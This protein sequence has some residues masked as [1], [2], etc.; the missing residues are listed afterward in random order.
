MV[1]LVASAGVPASRLVVKP[2]FVP[3]GPVGEGPGGYALFAGRLSAGNDRGLRQHHAL[4]NEI[5]ITI[6]IA[7]GLAIA[8]Y[9]TAGR[10]ADQLE[11]TSLVEL[12]QPLSKYAAWNGTP[13]TSRNTAR[14]PARYQVFSGGCGC[15]RIETFWPRKT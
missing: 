7:F 2:N 11:N 15:P 4:I 12:N 8:V 13:W 1:P 10:V 5:P 9:T 14:S 6:V 3:D